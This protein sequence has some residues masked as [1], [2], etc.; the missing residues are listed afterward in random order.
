[1]KVEEWKSIPGFSR[2]E[3]SNLG[4][5]RSLNYKRTGKVVV[6][7]PAL[8]EDGYLAT[9]LLSD[10][11]RYCSWKVHR[12]VTLT[13]FGEREPGMQVNHKDGVK[14]N[15]SIDNLEYC[16]SSQN[17]RH[18]YENWLE[19]PLKGQDNPFAKLRNEDVLFIRRVANEGGRYY[20]RKGLA[21]RFGISECHVK[22][23]VNKR[24]GAWS[25]I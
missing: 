24:R 10:N 6:L 13:F 5:I 20:G 8:S 11:G 17:V 12:F 9:M 1:M 3:A 25:H 19:K 23:I 14:T 4:R 22:E 2:Y 18:A 15:N 21:E 7:K 16:T